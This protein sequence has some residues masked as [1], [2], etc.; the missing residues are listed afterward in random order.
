MLSDKMQFKLKTDNA[1]YRKPHHL[2]IKQV[3]PKMN[4]GLKRNHIFHDIII[5][6]KCIVLLFCV[7]KD[8]LCPSF[9][10]E[11]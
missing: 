3:I 7:R 10:Y 2:E 11:T 9:K 5:R 8:V 6:R 4:H 1:I